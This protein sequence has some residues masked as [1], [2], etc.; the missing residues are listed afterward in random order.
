[1]SSNEFVTVSSSL[2]D[3]NDLTTMEGQTNTTSGTEA[4][5]AG[6]VAPI[7]LGIE[8]F[9]NI[10]SEVDKLLKRKKSD[11]YYTR[12]ITP[13]CVASVGGP[14]LRRNVWP[15]QLR[16]NVAAAAKL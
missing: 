3:D 14:S 6:I 2:F 11:V 7:I 10:V 13:K 16:R 9:L 4:P 8:F 1:M 15:T 12:F 5:E